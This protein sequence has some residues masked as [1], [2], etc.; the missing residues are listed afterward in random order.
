MKGHL[1]AELDHV[2]AGDIRQVNLC[3]GQARDVI[4]VPAG[5]PRRD[6]VHARLVELDER[7]VPVARQAARAAGLDGVEV[8]QAD[9]G[10]ADA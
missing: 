6:D 9:A 4:G 7:Y 3:A 10:S 1:R 2:P 8:L 5:H